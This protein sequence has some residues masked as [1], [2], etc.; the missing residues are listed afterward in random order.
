MKTMRKDV[1][2]DNR[3][4]KCL[5]S[6]LLGHSTYLLKPMDLFVYEE[7]YTDKTTGQRLAKCHGRIRPLRKI[8]ETDVIK[9]YILAQSAADDMQF[10]YERWVP[11]EDVV[12]I[13]PCKKANT[14]IKNFF[15]D[16]EFRLI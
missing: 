3:T 14:H 4:S 8:D 13:I 11:V 2:R 16:H 10:T 12:Q 6:S 1:K 5:G 15:T 9:W 7:H